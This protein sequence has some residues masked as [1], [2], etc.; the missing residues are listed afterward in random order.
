MSPAVESHWETLDRKAGTG[1]GGEP[2]QV[3]GWRGDQPEKQGSWVL[4][5]DSPPC[6]LSVPRYR[7]IGI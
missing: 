2:G 5:E 1:G 6:G 4:V 3:V 7:I